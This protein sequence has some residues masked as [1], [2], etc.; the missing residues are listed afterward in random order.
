MSALPGRLRAGW[1]AVTGTGAAAG[2]SLAVL[3]LA[4]VFVAVAGARV[5]QTLPTSALRAGLRMVP[6]S[7]KAVLGSTGFGDAG[8]GGGGSLP[9]AQLRYYRTRL[10]GNLS[11]WLPLAP[12]ATD[13]TG[14]TTGY[15]TVLAGGRRAWNGSTPPELELAYRDALP[16]YTKHITGSLPT[17]SRGHEFQV[18]VTTATARLFGVTVGSRLRL[19]PSLTLVVTGIIEPAM[20][21]SAFWAVDPAALAPTRY[22]PLRS[23]P[24]WMGAMFV[25]PREVL[26]LEGSVDPGQIQLSWG[27]PL[28][29]TGLTAA[30]SSGLQGALS[31]GSLG[32][33]GQLS[34]NPPVK[35]TLSAGLAGFLAA[36][37][38]ERVAVSGVLGLLVVS[39]A[40]IG[41]AVV[42]LGALLLAEQRR[43]EFELMRARGAAWRQLSATALR[44]SALVAIPAA[45]VATAVAMVVTPGAAG[46]LP[47]WL[48]ALTLAAALGAL[49]LIVA[50]R[51][52]SP[53][54]R[55]H[56]GRAAQRRAAVRRLVI[57]A[58]LVSAAA[59]GLV[60]ARL[61][62]VAGPGQDVLTSAAPVLVAIPAGIVALRCYPLVARWLLRAAGVARG[63]VAYI[64]LARAARSPLIAILPAFALVLVLATISFGGLVQAAITRGEVAA[65]WQQAGADA[66]ID[67]VN[68]SLPVTPAA[69]RALAAVPGVQ[70]VA[71]I[72]L[73]AG[74]RTDGTQVAIAA[75]APR[76]YRS[77]IAATPGP[78]FPA[79]ALAR[80]TGPA[81]GAAPAVATPAAVAELGRGTVALV[82]GST[83]Y[84]VRFRVMAAAPAAP[85]LASRAGPALIVVPNWAMPAGAQTPNLM[86]ITGPR[87]DQGRLRAVIARLVPGG[88]VTFRS[89]ALARLAG[90]PLPHGAYVAYVAG[91]AAAAGFGI[92]VLLV[93]LLLS[94]GSRD[95]ALARLA[96]MGL[97][98]RQGSWLV[99]AETVP[100]IVVAIAAGTGCAWALASLVGPDL[101]L[102][103]F[104]GSGAGVP[105]RAEPAA[106]ALA[107]AGLLFVAVATLA[108]QAIVTS[109]RGVARAMRIGE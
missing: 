15:S 7:D 87:L 45:V 10:R 106:M 18:A 54:R 13:W 73:T 92:A 98:A 74:M 34:L 67:T 39:L 35:V 59:G 58:A 109:R 3:V 105:V 83:G 102:A 44:A 30:Q 38:R 9:A 22:V 26:A 65:S 86:L 43:G 27:F 2:V 4:S 103:G 85:A 89:A 78:P 28:V 101:S 69:Q 19:A 51:L 66:V 49:P 60:V 82:V 104:T 8:M 100:E 40:A 80:P 23:P 42:V 55:R 77:L 41:L 63:A 97:S 79:A 12:A 36:F 75:V 32:Q 81:D 90:A 61:Q 96:A 48:A 64:G 33:L 70:H 6:T 1:L 50:T 21:G 91:A 71:A 24:Y 14:L 88:S 17:V 68:S 16:H 108:G 5:S 53:A 11:P 93:W 20:P 72:T 84:I 107:A 62:G 31:P 25:G 76:Q 29:V 95:A 57:E 99:L 56:G 37:A 94:A 52:L 47:W 46:A